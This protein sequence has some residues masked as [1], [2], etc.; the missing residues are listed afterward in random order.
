MILFMVVQ[1]EMK[2]RVEQRKEY[3]PSE[4]LNTLGTLNINDQNAGIHIIYN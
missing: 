2:K 4:T 3:S 1:E